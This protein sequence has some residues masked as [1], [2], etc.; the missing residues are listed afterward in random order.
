[1]TPSHLKHLYWRAGFGLSPA[2]YAAR[3][4]DSAPEAWDRLYREATQVTE[5]PAPPP[6]D[7]EA[8][9]MDR[10]AF[11]RDQA[12]R[13][14]AL[15]ADWI[16]RMANPTEPALLERMSLFWHGHFACHSR[17]EQIAVHQLNLIRK[18]ALG[19]F[20]DLLLGISHD[21]G[22]IRYL[23][24]QQNRKQ[25]PNENFAR[26]VMELFTL[27]RGNYTEQDIK[28]A[29]R[30][31]TG[32]SSNLKGEFVF[33]SSWHDYGRKTVFGKSGDF[34]GEDIIDLLLEKKETAHFIA[35]KVYRY[36]VHPEGDEE[37]IAEL[38]RLFYRSDYDIARL[39][40]AL[41][42]ADWF[43]AEENLG[44]RIKSPV[45]LLA[46][47]TRQLGVDWMDDRNLFILQRALGQELF[48]PPNVAGWP[49]GK[50]WID[51]STLML[52]LSLAAFLFRQ[53]EADIPI[54]VGPEE[55]EVRH[56]VKELQATFSLEPLQRALA[57]PDAEEQIHQLSDF[58]LIKP[59]QLPI[60]QLN[61]GL[62]GR[63]EGVFAQQC[64]RILSLPDYQTC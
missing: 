26:E 32:W 63:A 36:F 28:E 12:R 18:H 37:R 52:R 61:Q 41:F 15:S 58:L 19:N 11:I 3:H 54:R 64:L 57:D 10:K 22:M 2:E 62:K 55:R 38:G 24:N 7:L 5:L 39:M 51:N 1:M 48:H 4:S 59:T 27:G 46:G 56:P 8:F 13:V 31:F 34:D 21:P 20:R 33:R 14:F 40:E 47:L 17:S 53:A 6:P 29:A 49:Q 43:Y 44:A 16:R 23:N 50:A 30:A 25:Q 42:T 45:E 60:T 35:G 9:R